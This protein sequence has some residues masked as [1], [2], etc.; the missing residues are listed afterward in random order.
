MSQYPVPQFIEEEGKIIFFLTFRQFFYLV[1][2]GGASVILYFI[3]PFWLFVVFSIMIALFVLA[4]AFLK[5]NN[6]SVLKILFN[7][8]MFSTGTKNYTWNK[9]ELPYPFKIKKQ[10]EIKNIPDA[11]PGAPIASIQKSQLNEIKKLIETKR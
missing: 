11:P 3:L 5:I 7:F 1:G 6:E 10:P 9:K 4:M 8:I 2:G